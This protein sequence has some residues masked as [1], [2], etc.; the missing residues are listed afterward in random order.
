CP[1]VQTTLGPGGGGGVSACGGGGGLGATTT[2]ETVLP[3]AG[4]SLVI[5]FFSIVTEL[6]AKAGAVSSSTAP[7][8][9]N[10]RLILCPPCI[11]S[12]GNCGRAHGVN[13]MG[14]RIIPPARGQLLR[15]GSIG[16]VAMPVQAIGP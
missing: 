13:T 7:A 9:S 8:V 16:I 5:V 4:S 6:C 12:R 15:A 1:G 11:A 10:A 14:R 3:D 2:V